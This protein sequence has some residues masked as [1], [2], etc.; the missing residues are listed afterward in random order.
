[1]EETG[2]RFQMRLVIEEFLLNP[3]D[4]G[5]RR[6]RLCSDRLSDCCE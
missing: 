2:M 5:P 1:M 4:E 3:L 6:S